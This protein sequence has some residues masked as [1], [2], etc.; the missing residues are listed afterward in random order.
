MQDQSFNHSLNTDSDRPPVV[1][2]ILLTKLVDELSN[3]KSYGGVANFD[4]KTGEAIPDEEK[5]V[6]TDQLLSLGYVS[7]EGDYLILT[8]L[9]KDHYQAYKRA[10]INALRTGK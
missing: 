10:V 3:V 4:S 2:P 6:R 1:T 5:V 8:D 7:R 9:G